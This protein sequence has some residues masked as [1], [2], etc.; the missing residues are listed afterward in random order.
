MAKALAVKFWGMMHL[1]QT[2]Q[3]FNVGNVL[4]SAGG[5]SLGFFFG[6]YHH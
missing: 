2:F 5:L 1:L 3:F 6:E 4:R